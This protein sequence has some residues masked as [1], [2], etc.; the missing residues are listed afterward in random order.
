MKYR[1]LVLLAVIALISEAQTAKTTNDPEAAELLKNVSAKY[2]SYKNTSVSFKLLIQKPKVKPTDDERKLT[3]TI[4]GSAL[5]EGAKF[6]VSMNG[7]QSFCDGN[8]IWTYIAA[9]KEVQVNIYTEG[10]DIFS[11]TRIFTLYKNGFSYRI[12]EKKSLG[13]KSI[14]VVEMVPTASASYFKIDVSIDAQA[15]QILE[16]KIYERNGTRYIYQITKQSSNA[17]STTD[18]FIFDPKKHPGVRVT[19]LR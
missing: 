1:L 10:N 4:S 7:Q 17:P 5:I 14:T 2:Q 6:N 3:D 13:S 15:M 19:D 11:P 12:K 16:S 18:N 8:N 9:D